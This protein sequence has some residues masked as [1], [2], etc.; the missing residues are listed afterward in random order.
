MIVSAFI[1]GAGL[2]ALA[3]CGRSQPGLDQTGGRPGLPDQRQT[4]LPPMKIATPTGWGNEKPTAQAGFSVT[5]FATGL[6]IPRQMLVLP[7]GDILVAEGSGGSAPR[8]GP[9]M[10]SRPRSRPW[11]RHRSRVAI[12]S[13]C[14]AMPMAMAAPNCAVRS[15]PD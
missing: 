10:S 6:A 12:A 7:N 5:A 14:C 2:L 4:L 9:K 13:P 11:V 1:L 15:S 8:C 3:A